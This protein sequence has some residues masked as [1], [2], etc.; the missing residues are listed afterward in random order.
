LPALLRVLALQPLL[1]L[2][3]IGW[4]AVWVDAG[5]FSR[6]APTVASRVTGGGMSGEERRPLPPDLKWLLSWLPAMGAVAD[7]EARGGGP[8]G[9]LWLPAD[10][11]LDGF[12]LAL[13]VGA[14]LAVSSL[15]ARLPWMRPPFAAA[16]VMLAC[17]ILSGASLAS[18]EPSLSLW[19]RKGEWP[20]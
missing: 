16:A 13:L 11:L 6:M 7:L 17:V 8:P 5:R 2:L 15:S 1:W 9:I 14:A 12:L 20:K 4:L 19:P 10:R 18:G 3:A